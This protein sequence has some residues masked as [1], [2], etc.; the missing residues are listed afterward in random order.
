MPFISRPRALSYFGFA[1]IFAIGFGPAYADDVTISTAQT[2]ATDTTTL[3][4]SGA[5]TLTV[6]ADGSIKVSNGTA[7]TINGDHSLTMQGTLQSDDTTNAVA[8]A[9]DTSDLTLHSNIDVEGTMTIDGPTDSDSATS[10]IGFNLFGAN[11]LVGDITFTKDASMTVKGG[12][13]KGM[14]FGSAF[15]GNLD[16]QGGITMTGQ[17]SIGI[18]VAAP[19]TGNLTIGG[20]VNARNADSIAVNISAPVDG[21]YLQE[22]TATVGVSQTTDSSGNVVDAKPGIAVIHITN[23]ITGGMMVGGE[24]KDYVASDSS[25]APSKGSVTSYGGA[26]SIL[27]ENTKGDGTD[28]TLGAADNYGYG[29][30]VRGNVSSYGQTVGFTANA[31]TL[32]GGANGELTKLTSGLHVD[33][34]T[35]Y[36]DAQDGNATA[37]IIGDGVVVPEIYDRGTIQALTKVTAT[38]ASD[39]TVTY[40]TGGQAVAVLVNQGGTLNRFVNE[41]KVY[42]GS[43]GAGIDTYGVR[44]LSGTLTY[45]KNTGT[46]YVAPST[47]NDGQTI[48]L[49]VRANTTG[50]TVIN[51]GTWKGDMLLGSGN[52]SVSLTGGDMTGDIHFGEG[53]DQFTISGDA[54]FAGA[55][56][57]AGTLDLTLAGNA[58]YTIGSTDTLSVTNANITGGSTLKVSVDTINQTAGLLDVSGTMTIDQTA[59]VSPVFSTIVAD[60]QSYEI[61]HAGNLVVGGTSGETTLANRSYL[62]HV[63]L[64]TNLTTD[65]V[66]LTVRPKTVAELGLTGN[67]AVIYKNLFTSLD[68]ADTIGGALTTV[69]SQRE[70]LDAMDALL[71]D[72][73][74]SGFQLAYTGVH[75]LSASIQDRVTDITGR[76]HADSG[77]WAREMVGFG[78]LDANATYNR[79]KYQGAGVLIGYDK[80][81]ADGLLWGISSG[82]MLQ[83]AERRGDLGDDLSVFSPFLSTYAVLAKG[84]FYLNGTLSGWYNN[85]DRSRTLA[86]GALSKAV[87][88]SAHGWTFSAEANMGY[89]LKAGKLHFRPQVG[90]LYMRAHD[91]AYTET[92]GDAA[93][94][95]VQSRTYS[96][97]DGQARASL[98]YDMTWEKGRRGEPDMIVR[99]EIYI[100]YRY[101]LS[102]SDGPSVNA[103]FTGTDNWFK[104]TGNP[105][106]QKGYEGGMSLNIFHAFGTASLRYTY[107]KQGNW[108]NHYGGFNFQ[109]Q[110]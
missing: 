91:G 23:D 35:V 41:G 50:V 16:F 88:S 54:T 1:T 37:V 55:I 79:M 32:E 39:G 21:T 8:L 94:L 78:K 58:A 106:A 95:D 51:S 108:V 104:L 9:V 69:S 97:A 86:I 67:R 5:G 62:M 84:G 100:A 68:P 52:D 81:V 110:F 60:T 26:P 4:G 7:L 20:G 93:S 43:A 61:V 83:G 59:V 12:G 65:T 48:A 66:S 24:G 40:G 11:S 89:D 102:G 105:I 101:K 49:D 38:T 31:I 28:L 92:G 82:F 44:D 96:R 63:T 70:A 2:S 90:V 87:K 13:S 30:V 57:H 56:S 71:P 25:T 3:L 107:E 18:D 10:N 29:L 6:S 77:F 64:D 74:N 42:S 22:G 17:G 14:Y 72:V 47:N 98:G 15:V 19:V 99:P 53:A 80:P 85:A 46:W 103:R 76:G 27:I 109:L 73:S 34:G 45:V 75:Q 33:A 36:A